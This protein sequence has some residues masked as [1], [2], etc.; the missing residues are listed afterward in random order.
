MKATLSLLPPL[1]ASGMLILG[2]CQGLS[3]AVAAPAPGQV[4]VPATQVAQNVQDI[5]AAEL[6][7]KLFVH[8]NSLGAQ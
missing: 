6:D 5:A 4:A 2:V 8:A 7:V 3:A 1:A